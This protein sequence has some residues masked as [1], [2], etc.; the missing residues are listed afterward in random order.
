MRPAVPSRPAPPAG[1]PGA[2]ESAWHPRA[3]ILA[4]HLC[5]ELPEPEADQVREHVTG[6]GLCIERLLDLDAF[7]RLP[8]EPEDAGRG[9]AA[10][11]E[12][13]AE[14]ERAESWRLLLA[15]RPWDEPP[16]A[17]G[18]SASVETVEEE[19]IA[20]APAP[21]PAAPPP[22]EP[23]RP[24]RPPRRGRWHERRRGLLGNG[25][26]AAS[27]AAALLSGLWS[28]RL[29]DRLSAPDPDHQLVDLLPVTRGGGD[30][31]GFPVPPRAAFTAVIHLDVVAK[32]FESYEA[33]IFD[34]GGRRVWSGVLRPPSPADRYLTLG[35][36]RSQL[37]DRRYKLRLRGLDG[38]RGAPA[39][40]YDIEFEE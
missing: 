12:A 32:P 4:A 30:G 31:D 28:L 1:P 19:I 6:C 22:P 14:A 21:R 11:A 33:E 29:L 25:L 40:E 9:T 27:L 5:G 13:E 2:G 15:E 39:G 10:A 3:E 24:A 37:S 35:L 18:E 20:P 34:A 36:S 7:E 38:G 8:G 16:V 23:G 26:I 17:A